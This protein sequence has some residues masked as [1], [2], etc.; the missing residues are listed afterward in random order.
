MT[1]VVV[2]GDSDSEA[3]RSVLRAAGLDVS[4][5][6][7]VGGKAKLDARLSKY[8]QAAKNSRWIVF[9]DSDSVCPVEL[10]QTLSKQ[11]GTLSP[12]F[13]LRIAHSMTESW[14]LADVEGFS[15]FFGVS[16]A[17]MVPNPD[18]LSNAKHEVLRLCQKSRSRRI[19]ED[20]VRGNGE[21]GPLYVSR[22]NEFASKHWNVAN[23]CGRSESLRRAVER[24]RVDT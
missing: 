9:R 12:H 21:T 2:E 17:R 4:R 20:M 1:N 6:V 5:I 19:K 10:S 18:L 23:A 24:L 11:I 8:N 16:A 3:A 14:L 13:S 15:K 7:V 22:I